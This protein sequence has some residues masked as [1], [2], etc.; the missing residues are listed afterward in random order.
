MQMYHLHDRVPNQLRDSLFTL[1]ACFPQVLHV[2][3]NSSLTLRRRTRCCFSHYSLSYARIVFS[4]LSPY[5]SLCLAPSSSIFF[6]TF[7]HSRH[8]LTLAFFIFPY[9]L[10]LEWCVYIP[11][12]H[13]IFSLSRSCIDEWLLK[14]FSC[15]VCWQSP[16][17]F[18]P[19][20]PPP[21]PTTTKL[22]L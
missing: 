7:S 18:D 12:D 20:S 14:S 2:D 13:I 4:P 19:P 6:H 8:T 3:L 21:Q 10:R 15:P 17:A 22:A 11:Q 5:L 9:K 16:L 1:H